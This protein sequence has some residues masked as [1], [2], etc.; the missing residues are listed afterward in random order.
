M[1]RNFFIWGAIFGGLAVA[2]GAFGAHGLTRIVSPERLITWEKAA[3][4]QMYHAL[5]LLFVAWAL[6]NWPQQARYLTIAGWA[7]VIGIF[8]FSFSLYLLA[9]S[10]KTFLGLVTPFGGVSMVIGWF[11][12]M[13]A[14]WKS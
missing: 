12:L 14:A 8:L 4:Y 10:G 11:Y 7:F 5:A 1:A 13:L 9:V 3:R 2:T 6:T